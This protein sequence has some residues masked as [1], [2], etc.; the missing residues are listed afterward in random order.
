VQEIW[1]IVN[2]NLYESKKYFTEKFGQ[3]LQRRGIRVKIFDYQ[4]LGEE[5]LLPQGFHLKPPD[6]ICSFNRAKPNPK[7]GKFFWEVAKV[8]YLWLL[9]DPAYYVKDYFKTDFSMI[10]CVDLGD[11]ELIRQRF[12][13]EN[14][15]FFPHAVEKDLAPL[16]KQERPYDVVFIGTCYDPVNLKEYW[17]KKYTAPVVTLMEAAIEESLSNSQCPFWKVVEEEVERQ[18]L[19]LRFEDLQDI[20]KNVDDYLRGYDRWKLILSI[21]SAK[22]HVFG[23]TCWGEDVK[24]WPHYF[25][26]CPNVV[27][28][29]AIPFKETLEVLKKS[30]ISLNSMPFFKNGTHERIFTGT[31][32]GNL[33]VTT[34]NLWIREHYS[35]GEELLLYQPKHWEEID[36]KVDYYLNREEERV[37]I[38]KKGREK[39]LQNHTWD[40]RVAQLLEVIPPL[41]DR[42][43]R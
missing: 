3:A 29:P 14:V 4:L 21:K 5:H 40:H 23:G 16:E 19:N 41:L 30:K 36:E 37:Q 24:G 43:K 13:F 17:K 9:V 38:A 34:D 8:P 32:C 26:D 25:R 18:K 22:V 33:V 35:E 15:F 31:A 7:T 20:V 1:F 28:H 10:S 11:Y 12:G 42:L 27:I 39:T 2:Y 6:L